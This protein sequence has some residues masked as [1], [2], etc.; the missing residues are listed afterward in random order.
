M[1]SLVD[2]TNRKGKQTM[3]N[4]DAN[5]ARLADIK[6][7]IKELEVLRKDLEAQ[8][9]EH[10]ESVE[11]VTLEWGEDRKNKATV[12]YGSSVKIDAT[13][14]EGVLTDRQWKSIT[15]RVLDE[16]LLEDKVARG[17][18]DV[19]VVAEHTTEVPKKP[20][21]KLTEGK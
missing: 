16:R 12:V 19:N 8:L 4:L 14:L 5:L 6:A 20:F 11:V 15:M 2:E 7:Q 1:Q 10:F 3:K 13:G 17:L 9:I 21:I 18:I